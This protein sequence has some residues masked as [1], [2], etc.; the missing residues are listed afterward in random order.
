MMSKNV[1]NFKQGF[2][3]AEVLIT[4]VVVGVVAAMTIPMVILKTEERETVAR[5]QKTYSTIAQAWQKFQMDNGCT[6]TFEGCL[7][8][9]VT[10][11]NQN[12]NFINYFSYV[13][14][15]PISN[16]LTNVDWLPDKA[17]H[18]NGNLIA[19][20]WMGVHTQI[21]VRQI[22]LLSLTEQY[23]IFNYLTDTD[24]AD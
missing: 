22:I 6:G 3:L 19:V 13:E 14:K 23:V 21:V 8:D 24:K 2:T 5:V 9:S 17:Y 12:H 7:D 16:S 20:N 4:L 1:S 10:L 11:A 15:V 18:L